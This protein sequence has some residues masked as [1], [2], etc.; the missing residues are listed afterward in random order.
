MSA[1]MACRRE[2]IVLGK[3]TSPSRNTVSSPETP[4]TLFSL[5]VV[6]DDSHPM[7]AIAQRAALRDGSRAGAVSG[8]HRR[9]E[10]GIERGSDGPVVHNERNH[11]IMA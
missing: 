5:F 4:S 3:T 6:V 1:R 2:L 9:L 7:Y 10:E 11:G 8:C